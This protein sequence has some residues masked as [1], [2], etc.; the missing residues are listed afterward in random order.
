MADAGEPRRAFRR[1]GDTLA[2]ASREVDEELRIHL[3]W[4]AEELI[5]EGWAPA[6]ALN[7]ARRRFG[8]VEA[9]RS[10]CIAQ[11][12]RARRW[13][14]WR[15]GWDGWTQDLRYAFRTLRKAPVY[16]FV[17][18]ATL[19]I[20]IAANTVVFSLMNPYLF[21]PLP[22]AEPDRLVQI[23]GYDP[24]EQWDGGRF[25][26][27]QIEE[28]GARARSIDAIAG[29]YYGTV[30]LNRSDGSER[31]EASWFRGP[32]F[33]VL[34]S[35]PILGRTFS[36]EDALGEGAPVAVIGEQLWRTR[37]AGDPSIVG[38]EV[39][40]DGSPR[41]VIG[42]MPADFTF[43][44]GGIGIWLPMPAEAGVADRAWMS[45][46]P[47]ARMTSGATREDLR[48]ELDAWV[49]EN[50][51][52]WPD[53][54]GRYSATSVKGLR[55]ALNFAWSI[56]P[57]AFSL[58][59]ASVAFVLVIAC[60]NV[61]SLTLAR[62]GTRRR[63]IAVRAAI[64]A[65]RRRLVGQL[66]TEGFLLAGVGGAVGVAISWVAAR[67]LN[68]VIPPELFKVGEVSLDG[69]VL[70]FSAA[71]TLLTPVFFA[72]IPAWKVARAP[73][74]RTLKDGGGGGESATTLRARRILVV[75]EVGLALVLVAG[76]GLMIRSL[77][78]VTRIDLGFDA[79]RV[80]TAAL[81]PDAEAVSNAEALDAFWDEV[82]LA[83]D[84]LPEIEAVGTA[85]HLP[86]NHETIP[87]RFASIDTGVGALD[88]WPGAYTSRVDGEF[89]SSMG[90]PLRSGRLF[91]ASDDVASGSVVV[92]RAMAD[93]LFPGSDAV[94]RTVLY[95]SASSTE[96]IRGT[97]VGVV[98]DLRYDRLDG[99]ARP[100]LFRPIE[101]SLS[102]R[103]F[104]AMRVRGDAAAASLAVRDALS[105][106]APDV[107]ASLRPMG[108]IVRENTLLWAVSSL[109][110][111]VFGLVAFGLA[112]LGIYGLISYSVAQRSR[113]M[114]LRMALGADAAALTRSVVA[115]GLRLAG[116]GL[117]VGLVVVVGAGLAFERILVDQGILYGVGVT[118]PVTLT[119]VL[120]LFLTIAAG[121]SLMPARRAAGADPVEALRGE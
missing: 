86:L 32:L 119:V 23:G 45:L 61:A 71:V 42:V 38:R 75:A 98:D 21:R 102:R 88:G 100:H 1:D 47:V 83:V 40:L 80:L 85:S 31:I 92:T 48:L 67:G 11:S 89:F 20:G 118:D 46:H 77:T 22:F 19:A 14:R 43:P 59:L 90:L 115:E 44:F 74:S 56:L 33:D 79:E 50:A 81:S 26:V 58:L 120:G 112:A 10:Y 72:L 108:E 103:R 70:V 2:D 95:G 36:A 62:A 27:P 84:A 34:G 57:I 5:A 78:E 13:G 76:T 51:P 93:R 82:V 49:E 113:E 12:Q 29:Y 117:A 66:L 15:M 99:A 30:N 63:E 73:L 55:E 16:A 96:P 121:A 9:T 60:V 64:G 87:V 104:L 7:E 25:S 110:L 106:V 97:I 41:T 101:G 6:E 69:R 4:V 91:D 37:F 109:F 94:G 107:P 35:T 39:V 52:I 17:V 65:P 111:G 114:G 105:A 3:E 8:D 68:G 24:T 116:I 18:V 28:M 53:L 54:D